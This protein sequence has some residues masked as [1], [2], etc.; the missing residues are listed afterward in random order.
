MRKI[1]LHLKWMAPVIALLLVLAG[2]QP[3]GG[4]DVN[5][6]LLGNAD[7]KSMESSVQLSVH[8]V[9][10]ANITGED[11]QAVDLINSFS[12]RLDDMKVQQNGDISAS[13]TLGI[14]KL[15][16]PVS[17]YLNKETIAL[18][19]E[20]AKQ[21]YYLPLTVPGQQPLDLAAVG[22]DTDKA[23]AFSKQLAE[24]VVKHLPNPSVI[25]V[26][27][28]ND[29][30][31]GEAAA[32]TQ[33]HAEITGDELTGLAK[34]LLQSVSED[35]NGLKE[36]IGGLYDYIVP[37]LEK[38]GDE[39]L[40]QLGL[41]AIPLDDKDAVVKVAVDS[42]KQALDSILLVYDQE[43]GKQFE[44]DPQ[45]SVVFGKDTKL[46]TDIYVDSAFQVRKEAVDLNLALP[47]QEDLPLQSIGFKVESEA[48]NI[49]GDVQADTFNPDGA[50]DVTKL[51]T[52]PVA[53]LNTLEPA[54]DLYRFLR[55]DLG[56]AYRSIVINPESNSYGLVVKNNTA[57]VPLLY[58]AQDLDAQ[59]TVS[60]GKLVVTDGLSGE[61]LEFK[62]GSNTA[63][64]NGAT[65][66]LAEPAYIDKN[67]RAY[68]PLRALANG[69]H[70]AV[71]GDG[72]GNIVIE[73][74]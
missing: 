60:G 61:Q 25:R 69:L 48:W 63:V 4:V 44:Q 70:A 57:M 65:V 31:H 40:D 41:P 54:S 66:K 58:L 38:Q 56:V 26:S 9:P 22:I 17:F 14:S 51:D 74:Q 30:V 20:G 36:V 6:I 73:R 5:K 15:E 7:A 37:V 19:I 16:L 47:S 68:V 46:T 28:V 12:L 23:A 13:G 62:P 21:P 18:D 50:L 49:N 24:F 39:S 32:L 10:A 3:V 72:A 34:S 8:A 64:V 52:T 45:L 67:G 11:K 1:K 42:V 71:S 53:V 29:T 59:I 55:Y 33:L 2:C 35:E 27:K 43:I